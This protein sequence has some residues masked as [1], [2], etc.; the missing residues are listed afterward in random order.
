MNSK[1]LNLDQAPPLQVPLRFFL[2]APLFGIAAGLLLVWQGG[3]LFVV[4]LSHYTVA[5]THLITL[6]FISMVIFGALYQIVPVLVGS[7]MPWV[8]L[9]WLVH[10]GLIVGVVAL[11][12]GLLLISP[13]LLQ[14][15]LIA[16]GVAFLVFLF[17]LGSALARTP[18]LNVTVYSIG[19]AVLSLVFTVSLGLVSV[20]QFGFEPLGLSRTTL[21]AI[22]VYLALGGWLGAMITGVGY[23]VLPMFYLA[24]PF[25]ASRSWLV[26][27]FQT[28]AIITGVLTA[29]LAESQIWHMVPLAFASVAAVIFASTV[30]GTLR[31]RRR[32]IVDTTL[33]FW[34]VGIC[35]LLLSLVFLAIYNIFPHPNWLLVFGVL[36]LLG[37]VAA[38]IFGMLFKI[39]AFL[40]WL[41]RFSKLAGKVNVPLLKDIIPPRPTVWQ[42]WSFLLMM[43]MMLAAAVTGNDI[44]ARLAGLGMVAA[45]GGLWLI[46]L[47]ASRFRPDLEPMKS[48]N[49]AG[50]SPERMRT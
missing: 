7:L 29:L 39:V 14:L 27:I 41:H 43:V 38:I 36:F 35:C 28:L 26:L 37:F 25:P 47:V 6:G 16:L 4:P 1:S 31:G 33:R 20:W 42:W 45:F 23:S 49:P 10:S 40:I 15:A 9:A 22:H 32:K 30:F 18:S 24:T 11:V 46:L 17:Q 48:N 19:L 50:F 21:T 44:L 34:Y 13:I 5:L 2:T 12:G 3:N 8:W